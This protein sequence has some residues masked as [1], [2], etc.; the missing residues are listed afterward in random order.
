ML[1]LATASNLAIAE[2][3]S[4][5]LLQTNKG[6]SEMFF[7]GKNKSS[8]PATVSALVGK[9]SENQPSLSDLFAQVFKGLLYCVATILLGASLYRRFFEKPAA[10]ADDLIKVLGKRTIAPKTALIIIESAGQKFLL[11][12][13]PDQVALL[14]ELN[15]APHFDDTLISLYEQES[16]SVNSK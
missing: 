9:S 7:S 8:E 1:W 6:V 11:S 4:Q 2:E 10:K 5:Q 3:T 13:T 12:H 16:V 15:S 14:A